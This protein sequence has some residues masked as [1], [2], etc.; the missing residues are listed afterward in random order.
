MESFKEKK[1][2]YLQNYSLGFC[3]IDLDTKFKLIGLICWLYDKLKPKRPDLTYYELLYGINKPQII[4]EQL[5]QT[6]AIIC[7]D[8]AY[9]VKTFNTYGLEPNV[10]VPTVKE[11][12]KKCLP[13]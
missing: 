7:E 13:F 10:V 3:D 12:L 9:G 2:I 11:I 5:L 6:L 8:F 1:R 4:I